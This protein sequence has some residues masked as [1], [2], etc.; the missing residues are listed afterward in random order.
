MPGGSL[1]KLMLE[2]VVLTIPNAV[3]VR[4][5]LDICSG[6]TYLHRNFG[7]ERIVHGDIKPANILLTKDLDCKV[8][9]FGGAR[10]AV[11]SNKI[12][13]T[14]QRPREKGKRHFT[15][16][17]TAPEYRSDVGLS[18]A[19]DVFS[20]GATIYAILLRQ[21]PS[22]T[23]PNVFKKQLQECSCSKV[24]KEELD[25][26]QFLKQL[27]QNCCEDE[28]EKRI[29]IIEARDSLLEHMKNHCKEASLKR[30]VA[31]ITDVYKIAS[32][33]TDFSSPKTLDRASF[34]DFTLS[35]DD[36]CDD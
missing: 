19:M 29:R 9:D 20:V 5:C 26:F 4:F 8:A 28:P 6:I 31:D 36:S 15:V 3:R 33:S 35:L 30:Y 2:T 14:H 18:T 34:E 13:K 25:H 16:G 22:I 17:Y 7:D 1:E 12:S 24:S 27:M 10:I 21:D 32:L 23:L 11:I